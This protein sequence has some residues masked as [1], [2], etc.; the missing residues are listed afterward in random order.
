MH[1]TYGIWSSIEAEKI[2]FYN[3]GMRFSALILK[4]EYVTLPILMH[5]LLDEF[6][7]MYK[8]KSTWKEK[9]GKEM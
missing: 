5:R 1:G 3:L 2:S 8:M 6:R 9:E 7:A 4:W